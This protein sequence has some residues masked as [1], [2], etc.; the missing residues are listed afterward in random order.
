VQRAHRFGNM[1]AEVLLWNIC[2]R[3]NIRNSIEHLCYKSATSPSRKPLQAS[4]KDDTTTTQRMTI[5]IK[6][7]ANFD[8]RPKTYKPYCNW[9]ATEPTLF[10]DPTVFYFFTHRTKYFKIQTSKI[11]TFGFAIHTSRHTG[12][13]KRASPAYLCKVNFIK[14]TPF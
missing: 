4:L 5:N 11:G 13:T 10:A 6:W 12:K 8:G 9:T 7:N 3:F 2:T 1:A 14:F